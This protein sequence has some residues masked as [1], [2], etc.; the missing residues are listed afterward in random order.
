MNPRAGYPTYSLSRGAPSPLG[1]FCMVNLILQ[2]IIRSLNPSLTF[3]GESG[4]R[5]HGALRHDGF[6]DRSVMTTSVSLHR[7]NSYIIT[8]TRL[9]QA[10]I[11]LFLYNFLTGINILSAFFIFSRTTERGKAVC[12]LFTQKNMPIMINFHSK[13]S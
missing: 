4:I 12:P 7:C 13:I 10:K 3:G 1:Y 6:Q 8:F 9:C 11:P 5:T 2:Y